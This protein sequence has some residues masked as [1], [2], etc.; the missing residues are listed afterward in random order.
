MN[1]PRI[2]LFVA[3]CLMCV[4]G[5]SGLMAQGIFGNK[6]ADTPHNLRKALNMGITDLGEICVYCHTPHNNN[7]QIEAPLWNRETPAGPY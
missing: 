7:Q 6:V 1:K 2:L 4:I 3:V 5:S